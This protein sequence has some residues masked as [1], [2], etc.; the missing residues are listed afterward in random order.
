LPIKKWTRDYKNMLEEMILEGDLVDE[1]L[2]FHKD[3]TVDF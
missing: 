1:I 3:N 2:E